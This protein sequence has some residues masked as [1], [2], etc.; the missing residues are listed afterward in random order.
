MPAVTST[1]W[2]RSPI[3]LLAGTHVFDG[4]SAAELRRRIEA[5]QVEPWDRA[6]MLARWREY[7]ADPHVDVALSPA[8]AKTIAVDAVHR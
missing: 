7:P 3:Y 8:E 6:T 4:T 5:C 1:R 2:G